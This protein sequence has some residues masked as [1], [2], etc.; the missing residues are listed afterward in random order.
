MS[1]QTV[2]AKTTLFPTASPNGEI[3]RVLLAFLA[4]AGLF[5]VNIMPALVDGLIEGLGFSNREAGF[6]GSANVYGAA[7]GAFSA[8][9]V[10]KRINWRLAAVVLLAGLIA[11]D[12]TSMFVTKANVL[13][14]TR[15]LHGC[16]GG[17]LV[18][19]GFAV[20]SRTTEADRTF[21]YLLTIQFGLGGLGLIYLP[22]LVPEYGTTALFF[23][24][25]A[26][27]FVTLLMLP[28]LADYPP[29]QKV[30]AA[31]TR[32][33]HKKLALLALVAT[34]LFQAANMG[35]YAYAIG[36]G[37][38]AMLETSFVSNALGVAAWVAIAGSILVILMSTKFGRLIPVSTAII[39]TAFGI[40]L[41]HF[42]DI[43]PGG[44][45]TS[46]YWWSNV[47]VG[48]TWAFV[49]SYLLGMCS[50]FDATGQMAALGGF[51]SKMGLASGPAVAAMMVGESNYG[52]LIDIAIVA[53]IGCLLVMFFPARALDRESD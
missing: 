52:L 49:I 6:V 31:A 29:K 30:K 39:L 33:N 50:E 3:A 25:V 13:I 53:L 40:W 17:L 2:S 45:E 5:Y 1:D 43:K 7:F 32:E 10:V 28:F 23:S 47:L 42:S 14:G 4:T 24:L 34:F 37:K 41:L 26:F 44:W 35:I 8:V 19:I 9:F 20:I 38:H 46:V 27:S 21:G 51:A 22:G 16:V 36:I 15:F 12:F 11:I 48:I 18:G